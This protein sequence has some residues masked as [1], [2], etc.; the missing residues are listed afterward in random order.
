MSTK[1][2]SFEYLKSLVQESYA[3]YEND[4]KT[5]SIEEADKMIEKVIEF[6]E[7]MN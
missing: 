2:D 5:F 3:S 1:N 7:G 6:Y 4:R